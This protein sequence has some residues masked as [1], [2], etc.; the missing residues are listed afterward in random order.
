MDGTTR[1][2]ARRFVG[3]VAIGSG[4]KQ[5]G[6]FG[7]SQ[8][9]GIGAGRLVALS[10]GIALAAVLFSAGPSWAQNATWNGPSGDW[11]TGRCPLLADFVEGIFSHG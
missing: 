5:V 1:A 8:A 4:M 10:A 11:D 2:T 6:Q 3:D 7:E 9:F